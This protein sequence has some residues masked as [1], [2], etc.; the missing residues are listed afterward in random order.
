MSSGFSMNLFALACSLF[1]LQKVLALN[2]YK[3]CQCT[4]RMLVMLKMLPSAPLI[5]LV[6]PCAGVGVKVLKCL[7][8]QSNMRL[9]SC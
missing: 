2:V 3:I 7:S 4:P 8:Q 1:V 6:P 5:M 9:E